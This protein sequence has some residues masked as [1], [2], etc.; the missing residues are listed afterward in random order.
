M[1]RLHRIIALM[2]LLW[3]SQDVEAQ[4]LRLVA[5]AWQPFTDA[6]L[7]NGGLATDIVRRRWRA[8]DMPVISSKCPGPGQCWGLARV[9]TTSW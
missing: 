7:V 9:A 5:D 1:P 6:T 3:L 4:K 8:P 2:G